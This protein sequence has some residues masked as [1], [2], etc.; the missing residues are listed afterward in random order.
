MNFTVQSQG[1]AA[2]VLAI[3]ALMDTV[4]ATFLY[5]GDGNRVAQTIGPSTSLTCACGTP[6]CVRCRAGA[7]RA[8]GQHGHEI[9]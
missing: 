5:D 7:G 2:K 8:G 4:I 1:H 3:P 9:L 6:S